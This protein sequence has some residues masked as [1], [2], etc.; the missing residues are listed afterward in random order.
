MHKTISVPEIKM[1]IISSEYKSLALSS[2]IG[3]FF[4][5][6]ALTKKDI[7]IKRRMMNTY[8]NQNKTNYDTLKILLSS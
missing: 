3:Q 5:F 4:Y 7:V 6:S 2:Q 8:V 1:T